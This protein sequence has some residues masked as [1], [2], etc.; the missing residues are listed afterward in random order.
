MTSLTATFVAICAAIFS[1]TGIAKLFAGASLSAGIMASALEAGKI[2]SIS[3]LY[4]Y[5]KEIPKTLKY[6]LSIASI[7]LMLITSAGIYGYLSAAYAKVAATPLQLSAEVQTAEGRIESIEQGIKR[8]NDRLEQLISLRGQQ[9]TRLD[10][11]VNRSTTGNNTTIRTAQTALN[12][13][14]RNVTTLQNEISKLSEQRDSLKGIAIGKQ[15]EIETNGDIGTFVYIA[16]I[17]GTDLD[18]VV[19]WFTLIIVLVFDPLAVALVIAVNFL[20]K[21]KNKEES[22]DNNIVLSDKAINKIV[23]LTENPPPPTEELKQL[24]NNE[25]PYKVFVPEPLTTTE[26]K[27]PQQ[28]EILQ[29]PSALHGAVN[30]NDPQYFMRGD[31][32]WNKRYEWENDPVASKYYNEYVA[33]R[34]KNS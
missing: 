11:L 31:F 27:E 8:K 33:P 18:T 13:S 32:D 34:L 28:E 6:Y 25:E 21:Y 3:F 15:V 9:E 19:K 2:V 4:Q 7:V 20:L 17:L 10:Q 22:I 12:Q 16:K 24:L 5:W 29:E 14:D 30:R 26:V 1:V 23:E